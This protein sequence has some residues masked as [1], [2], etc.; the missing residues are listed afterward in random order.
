ME[1]STSLK[2]LRLIEL[3]LV[4]SVAFAA[5]IF[6]SICSLFSDSLRYN[7]DIGQA[8]VLYGIIY[9]LIALAVLSYVLFRQGRG[10]QHIGLSFSWKDIPLSILLAIIAYLAFYVCYVAIH[11][12]YYVTTGYELPQPN[13]FKTYL[14]AGISIGTILFVIINP[15]YEELIAR[16]YTISEVRFLTGSSVI[17]IIT[18]VALQVLYH[19][20]QGIPA[21]ISLGAMFLVVSI[22]FVRRRRIVPVILV[23]LYFDVLALLL[24]TQ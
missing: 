23:H 17:A 19:L 16:A 1:E 3:L 22:Y 2:S 15:I 21:A 7:S 10:L 14:D 12:G 20:Y 6:S 24:Y 18:S 8:T 13:K 5:T 9:E 4:I 11:F